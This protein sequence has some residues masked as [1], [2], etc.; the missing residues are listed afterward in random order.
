[1]YIGTTAFAINRSSAIQTLNGVSIDGNAAT[2]TSSSFATNS[3]TSDN[4]HASD[5]LIIPSTT[6]P[7]SAIV[8]QEWFDTNAGIKYTY[9]FDGDS[10]Q[11]VEM[12]SPS[13]STSVLFN[14]LSDISVASRA[15]G[16]VLMYSSGDQKWINTSLTTNNITGGILSTAR[17]GTGYNDAKGGITCKVTGSFTQTG[18]TTRSIAHTLGS[19]H[20]VVQIRDNSNPQVI[21]TNISITIDTTNVNF[22]GLNSTAT[23]NYTIIG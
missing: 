4:L 10:Y 22:S 3:H 6:M 15:D 14:M 20:I 8:G 13:L 5:I 23:Y 18:T 12:G 16:Q 17:G 21:L 11:W 9:Y 7:S 19:T 1:M 2:A